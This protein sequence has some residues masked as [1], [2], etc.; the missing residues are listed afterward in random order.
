VIHQGAQIQ[1]NADSVL[2]LDGRGM[3]KCALKLL[4]LG[5][6]DYVASDAHDLDER[7]PHLEKCC[8]LIRKR[9][10]EEGAK[11]LFETNPRRILMG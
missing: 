7:A 11:M 4:D 5:L 1:V 10:G 9:Y 2:G 3:K 6:V 8:S